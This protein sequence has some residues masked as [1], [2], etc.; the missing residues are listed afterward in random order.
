VSR[1][2]ILRRSTNLVRDVIPFNETKGIAFLLNNVLESRYRNLS[3]KKAEPF[4]DSA[5]S[6]TAFDDD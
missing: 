5:S 1:L 4:K 6:N 2:H 3:N